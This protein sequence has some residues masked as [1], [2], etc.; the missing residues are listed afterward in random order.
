MSTYPAFDGFPTAGIQFLRDLMQ[1]N[2]KPWFEAHKAQYLKVVQQPALALV[3]AL[4]E[5]LQAEFP[6]IRYDTRTNGGGSLMRIYRDTRFS[7]DKTPYKTNVAMLFTPPGERRM[8]SPGFGLQI[9]PE[10]VDLMAGIFMFTKPQLEVYRA[11]VLDSKL[12]PK[13][14]K[15]VDRVL[16]TSGYTLGGKELKRVPSGFDAAHPRAEWLLYKGLHVFSPS[17]SLEVAATP[18][19]V[20][21]VMVYFRQMAPV[22]QWLTDVFSR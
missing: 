19:L 9:T 15:A 21:T 10:Q 22:Q 2:T 14:V 4:G 8:E 7:P 11:A 5:R 13:L 6:A 20:D 1:N 18:A 16:Q 12:G 17:I 3:V